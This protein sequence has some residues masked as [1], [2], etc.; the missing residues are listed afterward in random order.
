MA[1]KRRLQP[2]QGENLK[3]LLK[4]APG[5]RSALKKLDLKL[6]TSG[7]LVA[8]IRKGCPPPG[9]KPTKLPPDPLIVKRRK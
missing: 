5:L 7:R 2:V 6:T 8:A 3:R 4:K 9:V 1:K